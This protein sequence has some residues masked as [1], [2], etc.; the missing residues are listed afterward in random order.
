MMVTSIEFFG[1]DLERDLDQSR[2]SRTSS[3]LLV[4]DARGA[5]LGFQLLRAE[6][7]VRIGGAAHDV[8]TGP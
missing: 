3:P 8:V 1:D 4:P 5:V 6:R 2:A 7:L